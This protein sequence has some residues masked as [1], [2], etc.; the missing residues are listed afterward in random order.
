LV[1]KLR[2]ESLQA[3]PSSTQVVGSFSVLLTCFENKVLAKTLPGSAQ[4][5][6]LLSLLQLLPARGCCSRAF[7]HQLSQ[8]V[9]HLCWQ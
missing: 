9:V 6:A 4:R 2:E 8:L 3:R 5:L 7:F 1:H